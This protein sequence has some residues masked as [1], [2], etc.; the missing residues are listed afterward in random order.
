MTKLSEYLTTAAAAD[1]LGVS[2][3]TIRSW[4]ESGKVPARRNPV[5]GYRLFRREDLKAFLVGI[6]AQGAPK[7]QHQLE[8]GVLQEKKMNMKMR[9]KSQP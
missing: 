9:G 5:N 7:E 6:E 4:A 2:Q 8:N 1:F 3:N